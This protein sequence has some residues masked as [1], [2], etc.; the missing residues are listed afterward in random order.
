MSKYRNLEAEMKR[1][2]IKRKDIA[3]KLNVRYATV[4]DK[5]NG[6]SKFSFDEALFIKNNY[7]PS[8]SLE[9][10][11]SDESLAITNKE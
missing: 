10:L 3:E 5:V 11:F 6:K 7:F 4:T 2:N 8:L 9:Y 1:S